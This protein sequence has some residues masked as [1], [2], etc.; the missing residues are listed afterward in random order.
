MSR[1]LFRRSVD[2]K[3]VCFTLSLSTNTE[4][5]IFKTLRGKSELERQE[6]QPLPRVSQALMTGPRVSLS[7]LVLRSDRVEEKNFS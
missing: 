2:G 1:D 7:S 6:A 4:P 3:E 5:I